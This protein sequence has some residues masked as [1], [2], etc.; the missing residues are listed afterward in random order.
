MDS[1][2]IENIL[3][4]VLGSVV[5]LAGRNIFWL[6]IAALGF[7][8]GID[9]ASTWQ[10]GQSTTVVLATGLWAGFIGAVLAVIFERVGFALAGFYAAA[11]LVLAYAGKL[12]VGSVNPVI[13][14]MVG[15]VGAV[16]AG[17]LTDWAII[18]L[19]AVA[20]AAAILSVFPL[21]PVVDGVALLVLAA[22]GVVVQGTTLT[23]RRGSP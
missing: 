3:R 22:I 15:L 12:G 21:Q 2:A 4:V 1:S 6:F 10:A 17:L 5:L 20:G 14:L 9:V 18:L 8:L 19:S 23:R 13:L 11:F 7:L 16:V